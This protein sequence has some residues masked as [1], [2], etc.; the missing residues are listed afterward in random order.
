MWVTAQPSIAAPKRIALVIGN[1]A[2]ENLP[3]LRNTP[4]D[5]AFL[6]D[7]LRK[8][9]FEVTTL[10]NSDL[11]TMRRAFLSF[12]RAIQGDVGA[13]FI[14]Y[15]GHGLQV[16]GENYLMPI[17]ANV[18]REDEV[19][20]E[21]I[22]ANDFLRVLDGSS[23]T[24]NIVVLDACR[25]NPFPASIRS[26]SSGLAPV[27]APR[28]TFIAYSTA[29]GAVAYDGG[30]DNSYFSAALGKYIVEPGLEIAQVFRRVRQSVIE[31][32]GD[33]QT[34]WESSSIVGEFFFI[35][36]PLPTPQ[37]PSPYLAAAERW[38]ELSF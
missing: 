36:A 8:A 26:L 27:L 24:V 19:P 1:G 21:G 13:T 17:D 38:K 5:A 15:A 4:K 2:Y 31:E 33:R 37:P 29:P 35:P 28:G 18:S 20:L 16:D 23:S 30:N 32:T 11:R 22:N 10:V 7:A 6:S 3:H 12:A 34:P 9:D 14:F 25:N